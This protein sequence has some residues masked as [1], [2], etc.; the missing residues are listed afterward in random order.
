MPKTAF[1]LH[2][3]SAYRVPLYERLIDQ[4]SD[5]RIFCHN[6]PANFPPHLEPYVVHIPAPPFHN[7][8]LK[9]T[10]V[11]LPSFRLIRELKKYDPQT[12]VMEGMSNIGNDLL[13]LPFVLS[14]KTPF[15][16]WSLGH[17]PSQSHTLRARAG[18]PIQK[19]FI[20]RSA[21]I[22]AYS[23]FAKRYLVSLGADSNSIHV[24]K[25]TLDETRLVIQ[26]EEGRAHTPAIR[27]KLELEDRPVAAFIGRINKEKRL[28]LL[29]DAF[30]KVLTRME[31]QQPALLIIGDGPALNDNIDYANS[32]GL[33]EH[34]RFAGNRTSDASAFLSLADVCIL[35]GLGGLAIN[36][37][38][39]HRIPVIC[40]RA[41]GCEEDLVF[42]GKTGIHLPEMNVDSLA[43]AIYSILSDPGKAKQMGDNAYKLVTETVTMDHFSHQVVASIANAYSQ[44]EQQPPNQK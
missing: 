44:R 1:L 19:W 42:T 7:A 21:S 22:L 8:V 15:V 26:A 38:F 4:L 2:D 14:R 33:S 18:V 27:K 29:I 10:G 28:D 16:W 20:K 23:T 32:K 25:N 31:P 5:F 17:I 9:K 3:L 11:P 12:V 13:A 36:H 6:I 34:I 37:A 24:V 40:S 35:P 43:E 39:T 41:D 30:E